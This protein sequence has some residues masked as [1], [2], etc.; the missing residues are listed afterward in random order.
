MSGITGRV[1]MAKLKTIRSV[2]KAPTHTVSGYV[3]VK[4]NTSTAQLHVPMSLEI[5]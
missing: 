1:A 5:P 3:L 2:E 4:S